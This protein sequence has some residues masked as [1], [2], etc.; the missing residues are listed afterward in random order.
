MIWISFDLDFITGD[1]RVTGKERAC[2]KQRVGCA[3]CGTANIGRA[4]GSLF[5]EKESMKRW[6]TMK[7]FIMSLDLCKVVVRD[8]HGDI[9][10]FLK[11][12]DI[13]YNYDYHTDD[14]GYTSGGANKKMKLGVGTG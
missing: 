6:N 12:D 8:S 4:C 10:D 7:A 1:C 9:Y 14:Y 3:G 11:R 2:V 13:V 5:K